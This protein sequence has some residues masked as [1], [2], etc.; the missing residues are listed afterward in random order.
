M[1]VDAAERRF[2]ATMPPPE[3]LLARMLLFIDHVAGKK[4]IIFA[5]NTIE[6]GSM[7]LIGGSQLSHTAFVTSAKRAIDSRDLSQPSMTSRTCGLTV[8]RN[9]A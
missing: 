2:A 4:L 8:K 9:A 5:M 7:R 6:G 1:Q 3:A